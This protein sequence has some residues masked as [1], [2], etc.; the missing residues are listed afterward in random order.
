MPHDPR[1][2]SFK[3]Q[4]HALSLRIFEGYHFEYPTVKGS[5]W[6]LWFHLL[7]LLGQDHLQ[8][9]SVVTFGLLDWASWL[10]WLLPEAALTPLL[11][12]AIQWGKHERKRG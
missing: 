1:F 8:L 6:G 9:L 3:T 2:S 10:Y 12:G 4:P 5:N 7:A 11:H